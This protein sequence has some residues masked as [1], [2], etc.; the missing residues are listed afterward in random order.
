MLFTSA[1][2]GLTRNVRLM[3]TMESNSQRSPTRAL[4]DDTRVQLA[5]GLDLVILSENEVLVQFGTRS[6][7]SELLRDTDLKSTVGIIAARLQ[8]GPASVGDLVLSVSETEQ[9]DTRQLIED[10]VERG[11]LTKTSTSPVDQYIRYTFEGHSSLA[12]M[13]VSVIGAGPV[14]ARIALTLLQHGLGRLL[15][16]DER[17]VDDL[18]YGNAFFGAARADE[19]TQRCHAVL[20][21]RLRELGYPVHAIDGGFDV[22]GIEAAVAAADAVIVALEQPS[23]TLPHLVNRVCVRDQKPWL[24]AAIDGNLGLAGPLFVPPE[25]ACYNDFR[26]LA[27]AATPSPKM[28]RRHRDH[29]RLRAGSFFTGLPAYAEIV[30]GHAA[31]AMVHFLLRGTSFA[32]GRV[33]TVDFDRMVIATE[34]VL[35]LPRCPVCGSHKSSYRPS[36]PAAVALGEQRS[37]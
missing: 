33:L 13:S 20:C 34:N 22:A 37:D 4:G 25:T 23:V 24:L 1:Q 32:V 31:L 6:Y 12:A 29:I 21:T 10:L 8:R 15:L 14:A 26:T 28:A 5:E 30:A 2:R 18:W 19:R 3:A 7:P 35:R 16:L 11:I 36:V 27:D 17:P 9:P